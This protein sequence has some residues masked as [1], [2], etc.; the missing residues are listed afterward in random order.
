MSRARLYGLLAEFA[1]ADQLL[2]AARAAHGVAS[3]G[4]LEAYSPFP[5]EGLDAAVGAR[6]TRVPL[7]ML[8]GALAGGLGTYALECYAAVFAYPLDIGGRPLLSW[9]AFLPP[10]LEM[11]VLGAAVLGVIAMLAGNGLPRLHHPLFA[12]AG[13]ERATSDRFFLVLRAMGPDFDVAAARALLE[14]LAPLS[15]TEVPS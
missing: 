2:A 10:A 14:T 3:P 6:P 7:W 11:T 13:F 5:I 15:L 4:A 1:G 9:P 8:L 12:A